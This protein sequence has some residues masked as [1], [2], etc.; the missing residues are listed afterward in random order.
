MF[1]YCVKDMYHSYLRRHRYL[2]I[3]RRVNFPPRPS[4]MFQLRYSSDVIRRT[5]K[6][7]YNVATYDVLLLGQKNP[8]RQTST[9][10]P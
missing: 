8:V 2:L 3:G 5:A 1:Q 7:I 9:K 6:R 10:E 4:W